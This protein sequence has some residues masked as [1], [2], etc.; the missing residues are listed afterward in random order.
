MVKYLSLF[1]FIAKDPGVY[2]H[3]SQHEIFWWFWNCQY[4]KKE[5][6]WALLK[7]LFIIFLGGFAQPLGHPPL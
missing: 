7:S 4:Y 3:P 6:K 2:E 1:V 5:E